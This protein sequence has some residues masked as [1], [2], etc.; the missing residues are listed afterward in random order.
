[1]TMTCEKKTRIVQVTMEF[2]GC[3]EH[4]DFVANSGTIRSNGISTGLYVD[5]L[6]GIIENAITHEIEDV[7]MVKE[8]LA[9]E[10][11]GRSGEMYGLEERTKQLLLKLLAHQLMLSRVASRDYQTRGRSLATTL[12]MDHG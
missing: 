4:G 8:L 9:Y 12:P 2:E 5:T 6:F 3:E 10:A 11:E 1:M 7:P